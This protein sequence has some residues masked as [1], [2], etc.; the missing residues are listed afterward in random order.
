[1]KDPEE[2]KRAAVEKLMA[3]EDHRLRQSDPPELIR[4]AIGGDMESPR[5]R[6][7]ISR[8]VAIRDWLGAKDSGAYIATCIDDAIRQAA[9]EGFRPDAVGELVFH[10]PLVHDPIPDRD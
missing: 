6:H 8:S 7:Q 2:S 1:M 5:R 4:K 9:K 10:V 3:A